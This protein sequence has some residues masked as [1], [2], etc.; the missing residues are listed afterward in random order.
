MLAKEL[1]IRLER[2]FCFA[3]S[4]NN[5]HS[6]HRHGDWSKAKQISFPLSPSFLLVALVW[7]VERWMTR[8]C[9]LFFITSLAVTGLIVPSH[10][11]WRWELVFCGRRH[12]AVIFSTFY[13]PKI[14]F[15]RPQYAVRK[16][17]ITGDWR[18]QQPLSQ[19]HDKNNEVA[20]LSVCLQC[21]AVL[22]EDLTLKETVVNS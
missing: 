8:Q 17:T 19:K 9:V 13:I 10:P 7:M 16:R 14:C 21:S 15:W 22:M 11:D 1:L 5:I 18:V 4:V 2:L 20:I 6:F 3:C 12:P